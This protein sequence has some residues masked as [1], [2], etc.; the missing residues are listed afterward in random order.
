MPENSHSFAHN[1]QKLTTN[2]PDELNKVSAMWGIATTISELKIAIDSNESAY[3]ISHDINELLLFCQRE[4]KKIQFSQQ[5][6]QA[7]VKAIHHA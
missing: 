4:I 5:R 7:L 6:R 3:D 2:I 1:V